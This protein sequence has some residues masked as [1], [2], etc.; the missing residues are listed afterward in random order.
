M[1]I[2]NK[3]IFGFSA[4]GLLFLTVIIGNAIWYRISNVALRLAAVTLLLLALVSIIQVLYLMLVHRYE[5][6]I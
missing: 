4:I 2:K 5:V 6:N 3:L 1:S